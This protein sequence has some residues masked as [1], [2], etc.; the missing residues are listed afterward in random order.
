VYTACLRAQGCEA[1]ASGT[2]PLGSAATTWRPFGGQVTDVKVPGERMTWFSVQG[3]HMRV[4]GDELS[5]HTT[6]R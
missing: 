3:Q 6:A 5:T 4:A 2:W 1:D